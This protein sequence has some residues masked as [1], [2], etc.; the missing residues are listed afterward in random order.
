MA[1]TRATARL[2]QGSVL[3]AVLSLAIPSM[4]A[5]FV[6][7]AY[8]IVDRIYI[9]NLPE[10]GSVAL[11]G[12]GVCGPLTTIVSSFAFLIGL[13]GAPLLAIRLGEGDEKSARKI[14]ANALVM[15]VGVAVILTLIVA[16]WG[17]NFLVWFGATNELFPYASDYLK[18]YNYGTFFALM[19]AGLN[20]FIIAQGRAGLGM[21]T[22]LIGA[23]SNIALDPLFIFVF[24]MGVKGAA[25]ATVMSQM[26]SAIFALVVLFCKKDLVNLSLGGYD[27]KLALRMLALGVSPF[28]IIATDSLMLLALNSVLANYGGDMGG[29]YVSAATIMLSFMQVVTMPLGGI[30]SGTQPL[31]GFNYGAGN[32]KRVKSSQKTIALVAIGYTVVMFVFSMFGADAFVGIFNAEGQLREISVRFIRIYAAMIIPLALQYA[33]VDGLTALGIAKLSVVLSMLRK[34]V[35]MLP[36]TLLLPTFGGAEWALYA[37]PIADL[38]SAIVSTTAYLIVINKILRRRQQKLQQYN[39]SK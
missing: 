38:V 22:S 4:L 6:N 13:G 12:V 33:F 31:L 28:L 35:I 32:V 37:E 20:C 30:T 8:G 16:L 9:G 39:T 23:V 21:V 17:N 26:F 18:V 14:L 34:I 7:V 36:L 2:S 25:L 19:A 27:L 10:I 15:L 29:M 1:D 24:D 3:K 5:Q 11:G